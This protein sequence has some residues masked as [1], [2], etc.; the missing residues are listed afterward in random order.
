[1]Y[2]SPWIKLCQREFS[3]RIQQI[4]RRQFDPSAPHLL[5]II[6]SSL[7]LIVCKER[8]AVTVAGLHYTCPCPS[9]VVSSQCIPTAT[10]SS[11]A[12]HVLLTH[13]HTPSTGAQRNMFHSHTYRRA[14]TGSAH[15]EPAAENPSRTGSFYHAFPSACPLP[16]PF[17]CGG[18]LRRIFPHPPL[19][20]LYSPFPCTLFLSLFSLSDVSETS[21]G[22]WNA[23]A[24]TCILWA[25]LVAALYF[26][27][28]LSVIYCKS[29]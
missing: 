7:L 10:S 8:R 28:K 20:S 27:A 24:L 26:H 5:D 6:A 16:L 18:Y 21:R 29:R 23:S 3:I 13:T 11:V 25:H 14:Y 1:M 19:T 9:P 15:F 2:A 12:V 22:V 4:Q 17:F